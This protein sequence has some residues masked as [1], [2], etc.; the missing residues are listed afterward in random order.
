DPRAQHEHR[1]PLEH[2]PRRLGPRL[3]CLLRRRGGTGGAAAREGRRA[4]PAR[5]AR[6]ADP[7]PR[8]PRVG[9][10]PDRRALP[11]RRGAHPPGRARAGPRRQ[12]RHE[13]QRPA[14]DRRPRRRGA[15]HA[16]PYRGH[17]LPAG[18]RQRLHGRHAVPQLR[19]RRA[20]AGLDQLRRPQA[21]GDGGA[22][23]AARRHRHPA[24]PHRAE[25]RRRGAR[26]QRLRARLARPGP[27]G[28]RAVHGAG[29]AG[30]AGAA[31]RR[32]R[33][34]PQGVGALARRPRRHRPRLEDPAQGL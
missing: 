2:V 19:R 10:R 33:R 9:D 4:R 7:S 16:G 18:Q 13:A 28:R 5:L 30:D 15:A 21:L 11:R 8:R 26:E 34:R 27:G 14:R 20:G 17:A 12:P 3:G 29:R 32:L 25:H 1:L 22:A 23:A 24:R 6:A 31:G